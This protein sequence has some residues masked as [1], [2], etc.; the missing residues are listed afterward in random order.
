[1]NE[2]GSSV[3]AKYYALESGNF[4]IEL[5]RANVGLMQMEEVEKGVKRIHIN[6][7]RSSVVWDDI[8][9]Q[10]GELSDDRTGKQ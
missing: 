2:T 8:A 9:N 7:T 1:M 4:A 3:I 6:R 10:I 5:R